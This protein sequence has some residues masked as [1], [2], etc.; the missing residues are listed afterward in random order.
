MDEYIILSKN[1]HQ[2]KGERLRHTARYSETSQHRLL[3]NFRGDLG[4]FFGHA[5][6]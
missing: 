6:V 1:Y 5:G 2:H 3:S 4:L